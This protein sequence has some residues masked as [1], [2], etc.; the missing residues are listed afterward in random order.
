[1]NGRSNPPYIVTFFICFLLWLL[2]TGS[3]KSDEL[4]AGFVVSVMVSVISSKKLLILNGIIL[5]P[6]S[7][8]ALLRY[9][10][11]FLIALIKAN[12]D[13]AARILSRKIPIEPAVVEIKTTM[14]SDLGKLILANSITLT[15]GTLTVDVVDDRLLIHWID[16]PNGMDLAETTRTIASGFETRLKGFLK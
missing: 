1:M 12:F 15:P 5:A 10:G 2:L 13:L 4:I 6:Q 16:S 7:L 14:E 11:Y 3:F 9:L 8:F